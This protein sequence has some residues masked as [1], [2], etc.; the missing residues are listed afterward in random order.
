MEICPV[1]TIVCL[2]KPQAPIDRTKSQQILVSPNDKEFKLIL[3]DSNDQEC[4]WDVTNVTNPETHEPSIQERKQ[5]I[6]LALQGYNVTALSMSQGERNSTYEQRRKDLES[7]VQILKAAIRNSNSQVRLECAYVGLDDTFSFDFIKDVE[8]PNERILQKGLDS[9]MKEMSDLDVVWTRASQGSI[10]PLVLSIKIT[11]TATLKQGRIQLFDLLLPPFSAPAP[12]TGR[13]IYQ[14]FSHL[15]NLAKASSTSCNDQLPYNQFVLTY[16]LAHPLCGHE[17]FSVF[18]YLNDRVTDRKLKDTI[19]LLD[20][21]AI[22]KTLHTRTL[23]IRSVFQTNEY[24]RLLHQMANINAEFKTHE[25]QLSKLS[26]SQESKIASLEDELLQKDKKFEFLMDIEAVREK[27]VAYLE[28]L[29]DNVSNRPNMQVMKLQSALVLQKHA[30]KDLQFEHKLL[31]IQ[32]KRYTHIEIPKLQETLKTAYQDVQELQQAL[33]Q[34]NEKVQQLEQSLN[35][36]YDKCQSLATEMETRANIDTKKLEKDV[37]ARLTAEFDD[38]YNELH[39]AFRKKLESVKG[40]YK[41]MIARLKQNHAEELDLVREEERAKYTKESRH[42]RADIKGLNERCTESNQTIKDLREALK[43]AM[44]MKKGEQISM[45]TSASPPPSAIRKTRTS[46]AKSSRKATTPVIDDDND[47][48]FILSVKKPSRFGDTSS[49]TKVDE[50]NE[51][52]NEAATSSKK[53]KPKKDEYSDDLNEAAAY[54]MDLDADENDDQPKPISSKPRRANH[55]ETII[56]KSKGKKAAS[57]ATTSTPSPAQKSLEEDNGFA[58]PILPLASIEPD[59]QSTRETTPMPPHLEEEEDAVSLVKPIRPKR[60]I[61]KLGNPIPVRS[62]ESEDTGRLISRLEDANA[63]SGYALQPIQKQAKT[64]MKKQNANVPEPSTLAAKRK[65]SSND[66]D[67]NAKTHLNPIVSSAK[68]MPSHFF[69]A[70]LSRHKGWAIIKTLVLQQQGKNIKY[71]GQQKRY[72]VSLEAAVG[73]IPA[74]TAIC[75]H[76]GHTAYYGCRICETMTIAVPSRYRYFPQVPDAI[77][78]QNRIRDDF[79]TPDKV[80]NENSNGSESS[81]NKTILLLL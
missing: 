80:G 5:L 44:T 64:S 22:L 81:S 37:E 39:A 79:L 66:K 67:A 73:E 19:S 14:S 24:K 57:K 12:N 25:Q 36:S 23:P 7:T 31:E 59:S 38:K 20:F 2:V 50:S 56:I 40:S 41:D 1:N 51:D 65:W 43:K 10:L 33:H 32:C 46:S 77:P 35:E 3:N 28:A 9:V 11:H 29:Y 62:P 74:C 55:K 49:I 71:Q 34:S 18:L 72:T 8:R 21:A 6:D 52:H 78:P 47:D 53:A 13:T 42:L 26:A 15:V 27:Q 48:N 69:L 17:K 16:L 58:S 61:R 63:E 45:P 76:V 30:Y 54:I 60:R 70:I 75:R 4:T 68:I